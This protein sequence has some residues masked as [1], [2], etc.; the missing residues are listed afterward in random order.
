[1]RSEV[2][3]AIQ[4]GT[5]RSRVACAAVASVNSVPLWQQGLR[6]LCGSVAQILSADARHSTSTATE[7][8]NV[9]GPK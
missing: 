4:P 3:L 5:R 2:V 7:R 1:M 6:E 8:S 9:T